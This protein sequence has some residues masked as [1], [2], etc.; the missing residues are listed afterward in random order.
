MSIIAPREDR[1]SLGLAA[2][3][4]GV[5]FFT[6]IDTSAKWLIM[7]GV[8]PLQV[9]F[10]RYAGH[11]ITS[12]A[13]FLPQEGLGIFRSQRPALQALR[14]FSLLGS[15]VLNFN[16]LA[17]LPITVTTT[18]MF[19]GPIVVTL[20]SIPML[21]EVVGIHRIAAVC[22]GFIGVLVVMQPWGA[23]FDP[24][25]F[26]VLGALVCSSLYFI[27]TRMLAGVERN[28]TSQIWGSG[29]PV[30]CIA[31]FVLGGW[32]WP[33]SWLVLFILAIIGV[34]GALAHI[35]VTSAHRLADASILAPVIYIQIVLAA[36]AG[37]LV[38]DT[39]PTVWTLA[40]G[41]IIV[42]AGLYIWHRER[43]R[44]R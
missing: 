8:L 10:A 30:V 4:L 40:G 37:I 44:L 32:V 2:M 14:S 13:V 33:E 39:W 35:V 21:G 18:I 29:V 20:L 11:L 16:A 15:T 6:C 28:A 22:I 9:V 12:L 34:F 24:A 38:F 7:A 1:T 27:L 25:M 3:A 26:L 5:V 23:G 43:T 31:P 36:I 41:A 42:A 17:H 19:A